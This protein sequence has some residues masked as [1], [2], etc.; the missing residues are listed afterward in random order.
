[1]AVV[2]HLFE[3]LKLFTQNPLP[4][5]ALQNSLYPSENFQTTNVMAVS[6]QLINLTFYTLMNKNRAY[7]FC[8]FSISFFFSLSLRNVLVCC[9]VYTK[10]TQSECDEW[11]AIDRLPHSI[12]ILR[13]YRRKKQEIFNWKPIIGLCGR[14]RHFKLQKIDLDIQFERF[15]ML[16]NRNS[17]E[18]NLTQM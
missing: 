15:E 6:F 4:H 7:L 13:Y 9:L 8:L 14:Y 18:S 17:P 11:I 10:V 3:F 5:T 1:M 12:W 2:L 16:P